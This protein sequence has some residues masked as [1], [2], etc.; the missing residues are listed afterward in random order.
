VDRDEFRALYDE[1]YP[2]VSNLAF[3]L[4]GN[5][6][7]CDDVAQQVFLNIAHA[8]DQFR[9]ESSL[10]TWIYRITVNACLRWIEH[11]ASKRDQTVEDF[12]ALLDSAGAGP[13]FGPDD[14]A[15]LAEVLNMVRDGCYT[16]LAA[17]LPFEQRVVFVFVQMLDWSVEDVAHLLDISVL[18]V[19]SRLHRARESMAAFFEPHCG[20]LNPTNPCTCL[21]R[22][23]L[24]AQLDP[25]LLRRATSRL[26]RN[27]SVSRDDQ[28]SPTTL[29]EIVRQ[30][31]A[32]EGAPAAKKKQFFRVLETALANR[33]P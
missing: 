17:N 24:C 2:L 27:K 1:H 32:H 31:P 6:S 9:G 16:A 15:L 22:L 23:P 30:L 8:I 12:D 33:E 19:K 28:P 4:L 14:S 20:H 11:R 13:Q 5:R 21:S 18:A 3:K 10:K 25:E 26:A 7:D 29:I